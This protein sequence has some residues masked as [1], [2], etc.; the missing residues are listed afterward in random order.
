[1]PE[2][3]QKHDRHWTNHLLGYLI[4]QTD[5]T[6]QRGERR[7]KGTSVNGNRSVKLKTSISSEGSLCLVQN[8]VIVTLTTLS[9]RESNMPEDRYGCQ[10]WSL[11]SFPSYTERP[12][13]IFARRRIGV[14]KISRRSF[15]SYASIRRT[16]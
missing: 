14:E 7:E 13:S 9:E 16:S 2:R 8:E 3:E 15:V 1:M 11:E 6:Q 5:R 12:P 10:R 4:K